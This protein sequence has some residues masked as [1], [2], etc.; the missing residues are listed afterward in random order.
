MITQT[1]D[2]SEETLELYRHLL[3][4][5]YFKDLHSLRIPNKINLEHD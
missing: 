1:E 2:K 4:F 5:S 3:R